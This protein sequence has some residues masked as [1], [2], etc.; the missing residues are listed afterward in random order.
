MILKSLPLVVNRVISKIRRLVKCL[1]FSRNIKVNGRI[2]KMRAMMTDLPKPLNEYEFWLDTVYTAILKCF[3]GAFIDVGVN[4][5]QT[6]FTL[7]RLDPS[8][9]YVGFEP[10][11]GSALTVRDFISRNE[12]RQYEIVPVALSDRCGLKK[13]YLTRKGG[14]D[15]GASTAEG[16]RPKTFYSEE[17]IVPLLTGD[18]ALQEIEIKKIAVIKID[19]EGAEYEVLSGFNQTLQSIR[20]AVVFEVLDDWVDP[21][22]NP[23]LKKNSDWKKASAAQITSLFSNMNYQLFNIIAE[24]GLRPIEHIEIRINNNLNLCNYVAIPTENVDNFMVAV[25]NVKKRG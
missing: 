25:K 1:G 6:L 4:R 3:P 2:Y 16:L 18:V 8:R 22:S 9:R 14:F 19:V 5:A 20:P 11:L 17:E 7:L 10:Q 24:E 15:G 12:L 23:I 21:Q 13:L